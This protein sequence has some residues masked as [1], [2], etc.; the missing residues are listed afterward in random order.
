MKLPKLKNWYHATDI[1]TADKIMQT[2]FLVPQKHKPGVTL[3]LF[4]AGNQEKAG[5][6]LNRRGIKEYVMFKVARGKL[7]P[8]CI[9]ANPADKELTAGAS[10]RYL[11]VVKVQDCDVYRVVDRRDLNVPG[12]KIVTT[13][14]GKT[15]YEC[16]D[17]KA[18]E[19][20]MASTPEGRAIMEQA[21]QEAEQ[22]IANKE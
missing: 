5:G 22:K 15:G 19:D 6:Y 17:V 7:D 10:M 13:G 3:G 18:F 12:F 20:F 8:A 11:N 1:E 9:H 16:V 21:K 2:G 4:F 14:N